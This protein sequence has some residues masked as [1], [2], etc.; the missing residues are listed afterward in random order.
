MDTTG[1][2]NV[3]FTVWVLKLK[4]RVRYSVKKHCSPVCLV[5][6]VIKRVFPSTSTASSLCALRTRVCGT[7]PDRSIWWRPLCWRTCGRWELASLSDSRQQKRIPRRSVEEKRE[8]SFYW[9]KPR[10]K[11]LKSAFSSLTTRGRLLWLYRSLC[12]MC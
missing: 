1:L 9:K 8:E 12:F 10:L 3:T 7:C 6:D 2:F 11:R 5:E 4:L